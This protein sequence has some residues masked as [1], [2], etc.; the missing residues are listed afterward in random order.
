M[1]SLESFRSLIEQTLVIPDRYHEPQG[2]QQQGDNE[3]IDH[4]GIGESH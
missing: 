1:K 2:E 4:Q 3:R